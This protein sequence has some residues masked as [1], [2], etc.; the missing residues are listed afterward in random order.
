MATVVRPYDWILDGNT[1]WGKP[2]ETGSLDV[3]ATDALR[4]APLPPVES[5][6]EIAAGTFDGWTVPLGD[7]K[8]VV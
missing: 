2:E 3:A 8:S 4:L 7:R 6:A 5:V 1:G